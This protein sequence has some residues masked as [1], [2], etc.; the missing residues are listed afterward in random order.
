[1]STLDRPAAE[2]RIE[3]AL[4]EQWDPLGVASTPGEHPE[5]HT[6][7]HELYNLLARGASD[8]QIVRFL[9]SAEVG[10]L[11]HPELASRDL[12]PLMAELRTIERQM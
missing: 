6:Y 7:A 4:L 8:T 1:M 11:G 5:Y 12:A 2:A 3:H 9:H 10:V